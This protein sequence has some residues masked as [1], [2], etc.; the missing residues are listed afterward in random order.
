MPVRDGHP[1]S[2]FPCKH[3]SINAWRFVDPRHGQIPTKA[4]PR[5][6]LARQTPKLPRGRVVAGVPTPR[7]DKFRQTTRGLSAPIVRSR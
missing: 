7:I 6:P 5:Q 3:G 4:T 2:I 1:R